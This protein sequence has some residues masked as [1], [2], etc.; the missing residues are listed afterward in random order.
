MDARAYLENLE[1]INYKIRN[2][3]NKIERWKGIAEGSTG[4]SDGERVQSSGNKQKMASAVVEYADLER[5]IESL[6][7]ERDAIE[8]NIEKLTGK[9]YDLIYKHYVLG[10]SIKTIALQKGLSPSW[11]TTTHTRALKSMQKILD[12][13]GI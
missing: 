9:Q 2:R 1:T 8:K 7:A 11:G 4:N 10:I 5:E 13:E 3:K 6:K 12:A